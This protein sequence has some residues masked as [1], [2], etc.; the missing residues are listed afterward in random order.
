M[1]GNVIMDNAYSISIIS[2]GH[3][4]VTIDLDAWLS[5]KQFLCF[6]EKISDISKE[7]PWFGSI[8]TLNK[9]VLKYRSES[10]FP[11]KGNSPKQKVM[12]IL[13]N[14]ATH[15]VANGMFFF[16]KNNGE[17]HQFWGRL[18][19]AGLLEKFECDS[20]E[21]EADKRRNFILAEGCESDRYLLGLTTFYSFPTPVT[22]RFKDVKG[23]ETLF[24]DVLDRLQQME[25]SRL[26]SYDFSKDAI[27]VFTQKS[28]YQYVK[29]GNSFSKIA[30]WPLRGK[31]SKGEELGGI[32]TAL[33]PFMP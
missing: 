21:E 14:P 22:G 5:R 2:N 23:V 33:Q 28:S 6:Q 7:D 11:E 8:C 29:S 16:S 32:L 1:I 15:S 13:G 31:G 10:L 26:V 17:R 25:Y 20:R 24:E 12:M 9:S 27:W 19:N 30:Y 3:Y 18:D 4:E